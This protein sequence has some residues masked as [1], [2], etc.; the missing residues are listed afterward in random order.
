MNELERISSLEEYYVDLFL[1]Y[2]T[3]SVDTLEEVLSYT[4]LC[5]QILER[6]G[7]SLLFSQ[8]KTADAEFKRAHYYNDYT[9][10]DYI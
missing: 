2:L 6:S 7:S 9:G 4:E 1:E 3:A 8:L 10:E 5:R